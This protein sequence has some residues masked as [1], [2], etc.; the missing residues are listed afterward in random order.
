MPLIV[1]GVPQFG[2]RLYAAGQRERTWSEG[3]V[4]GS[5]ELAVHDDACPVPTRLLLLLLLLL[6]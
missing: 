5:N 6:V 2:L 1:P 3:V 4:V